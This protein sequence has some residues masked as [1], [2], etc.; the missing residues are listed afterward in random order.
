VPRPTSGETNHE[1]RA[2]R[3][4]PPGHFVS[5]E[6]EADCSRFLREVKDFVRRRHDAG[7][8]RPR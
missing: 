1:P 6:H 4:S 7:L 5:D 3:D 8:E 2:E